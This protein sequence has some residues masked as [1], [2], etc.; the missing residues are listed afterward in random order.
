METDYRGIMTYKFE[1]LPIG[2][3]NRVQVRLRH[4]TD[5]CKIWRDGSFLKKNVHRAL[6]KQKRLLLMGKISM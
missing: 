4:Y 1:Y 5:E 3:F 6:I 2:L